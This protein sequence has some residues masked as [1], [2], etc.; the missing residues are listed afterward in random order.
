MEASSPLSGFLNIFFSP[1]WFSWSLPH[2]GA[3][4][5][6]A[7]ISEPGPVVKMWKYFHSHQEQPWLQAPQLHLPAAL[8]EAPPLEPAQL[9]PRSGNLRVN[10]WSSRRPP[11]TCSN[12]LLIGRCQALLVTVLNINST[13]HSDKLGLN[14][15]FSLR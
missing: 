5:Q 14:S 11:G 9:S 15:P 3:D 13:L 1:A 10:S 12:S 4:V 8:A 2:P 7:C 6:Q